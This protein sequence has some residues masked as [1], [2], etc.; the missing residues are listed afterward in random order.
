MIDCSPGLIVPGHEEQPRQS[1]M[2]HRMQSFLASGAVILKRTNPMRRTPME[3][4]TL[5]PNGR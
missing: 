4:C 5:Q 2:F 3:Q 1:L